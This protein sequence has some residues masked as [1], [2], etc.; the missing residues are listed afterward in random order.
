MKTTVFTGNFSNL[1]KIGDFYAAAAVEAGLDDKSA[2][3]V[4]LAVDEAVTN[5]I[6]HAYGGQDL[7]DIECFYEVQPDKLIIVIKDS[8]KPFDPDIVERPDLES[9]PCSREPHGLG[10]HFMRL[11][12]DSLEFTF[13]GGG[14]VLTMVKNRVKAAKPS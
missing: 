13:N 7:G 10:L 9:D 5:I 4:Q 2:Y 12:M 14:N 3:E 6:E 11:L 1:D 8:G